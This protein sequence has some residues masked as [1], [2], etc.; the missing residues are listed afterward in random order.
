MLSL[1]ERLDRMILSFDWGELLASYKDGRGLT[2]VV[3]RLKHL[4]TDKDTG[5]F[6]LM[7]E[8]RSGLAQRFSGS[9]FSNLSWLSVHK[10]GIVDILM[11]I[12]RDTSTFTLDG[13]VL[14]VRLVKFCAIEGVIHLVPPDVRTPCAQCARHM[15]ARV[16]KCSPWGEESVCG[17]RRV[18]R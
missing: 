1:S 5:R 18:S 17:Y 15:S 2:G 6:E 16:C 7:K 11:T 9:Q 14:E 13:G 12:A 4:H 3:S 10:S 8:I